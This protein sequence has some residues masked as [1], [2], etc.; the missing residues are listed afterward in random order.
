M[1]FG[2]FAVMAGSVLVMVRCVIMVLG[3]FMRHK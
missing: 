2:G 1:V 3:C